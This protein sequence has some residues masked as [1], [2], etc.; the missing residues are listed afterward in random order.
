MGE[1]SAKLTENLIYP[2]VLHPLSLGN[3]NVEQQ[4]TMLPSHLFLACVIYRQLHEGFHAVS[5]SLYIDPFPS[6]CDLPSSLPPWFSPCWYH[7]VFILANCTGSWAWHSSAHTHDP[8]NIQLHQ[9]RCDLKLSR[10]RSN[11]LWGHGR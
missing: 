10:F 7:A 8:Q 1:S 2:I 5:S 9:H 4:H 6:S 3:Q 11:C